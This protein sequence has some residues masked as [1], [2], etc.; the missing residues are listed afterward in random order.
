MRA[1]KPR[2]RKRIL[3]LVPRVLAEF[4][5]G[6]CG[7]TDL[8][9]GIPDPSQRRSGTWTER[10][11]GG[12]IKG[13]AYGAHIFFYIKGRPGSDREAKGIRLVGKS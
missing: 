5:D 7:T 10:S 13:E 8:Q 9:R 4:S 3:G 2:I 12:V 1:V 11:N 6:I